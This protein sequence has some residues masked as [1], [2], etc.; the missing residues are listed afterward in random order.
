M[1]NK[2]EIGT[3]TGTILTKF[4]LDINTST[5][6]HRQPMQRELQEQRGGELNN[7]YISTVIPQNSIRL[8]NLLGEGMVLCLLQS[9]AS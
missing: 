6:V 7:S 5:M 3:R 9:G 8:L 2:G 4:S 1:S